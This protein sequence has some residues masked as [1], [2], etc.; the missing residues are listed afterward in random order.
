VRSDPRQK[1]RRRFSGF[2]WI[3]LAGET[4]EAVATFAAKLIG[5][6]VT[7]AAIAR[8]CLRNLAEEFYRQFL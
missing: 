2:R 1:F 3:A 7:G 8:L 4:L 6:E 5:G